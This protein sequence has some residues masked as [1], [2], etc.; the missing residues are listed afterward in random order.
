L[1]ASQLAA[2]F[3]SSSRADGSLLRFQFKVDVQR[4]AMG[5]YLAEQRDADQRTASQ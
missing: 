2:S 1:A 4:L 3:I 5:D